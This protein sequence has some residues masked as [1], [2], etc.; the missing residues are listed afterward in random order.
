MAARPFA[1][2]EAAS[3]TILREASALRETI[4]HATV[5]TL[6]D[7]DPDMLK[8]N[9][10]ASMF[11]ACIDAFCVDA[12]GITNQAVTNGFSIAFGAMVASELPP[13]VW[14]IATDNMAGRALEVAEMHHRAF[15][16]TTGMQ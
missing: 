3:T 6:S 4:E 9:I 7:A 10:L 11:K 12:D 15:T 8:A 14:P 2:S 1:F 13:E 16:P 5:R